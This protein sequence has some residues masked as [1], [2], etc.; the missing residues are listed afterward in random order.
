VK[1]ASDDVADVPQAVA[2]LVKVGVNIPPTL[3]ARA[4]VIE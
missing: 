3:L 4:E 1:L 2:K